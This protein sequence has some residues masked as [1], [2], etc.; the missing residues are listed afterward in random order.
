MDEVDL[1]SEIPKSQNGLQNPRTPF[2]WLRPVGLA[3]RAAGGVGSMQEPR[4]SLRSTAGLIYWQPCRAAL[5]TPRE[6]RA[7]EGEANKKGVLGF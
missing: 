1:K 3:L 4:V 2:F 5:C 7:R 6:A